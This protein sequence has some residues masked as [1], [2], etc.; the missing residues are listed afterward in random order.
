MEH[1][2][3][4]STQQSLVVDAAMLVEAAVL[5]RH[6]RLAQQLGLLGLLQLRAKHL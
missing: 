2:S 4:R 3:D 5:D 1:V 6:G